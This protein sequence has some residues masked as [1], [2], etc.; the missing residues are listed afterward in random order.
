M[1]LTREFHF[2]AAHSLTNYEPGH[3]N[4]RMHGHSFRVRVTLE[5]QPAQESGQIMD[6]TDFG[7]VLEA[8]RGQLD[9]HLL[10]EIEGLSLPTLENICLWL[11]DNLHTD[12]PALYAIE[13]FRDSLGQSCLY[14]G[15]QH[16][17]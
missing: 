7:T 3:P 1:Q 12:L 5:G 13:V 6:L 4:T 9:H 11:W 15:S 17:R 2:D 10:N 14:K 16:G 8:A